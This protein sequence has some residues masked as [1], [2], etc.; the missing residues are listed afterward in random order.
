MKADH[1]DQAL[2]QKFA[3][4]GE[5]LVF[6]HD[7]ESEFTDYVQRG[8]AGELET[9]NVLEIAKVGGFAAKLRLE[10]DD[11]DG[12]YLIY[13]TGELPR[14]EEDWLLDIRLYSAAFH[15]DIASLWLNELSL[16]T[17]LYLR[18]H[19]KSRA[20]FMGAKDRRRKLAQLVS[21]DDDEESIDRKMIAVLVGS[22]DARPEA[23]IQALCHGHVQNGKF[24]L[25]QIPDSMVVLEKMSLIDR[26]W[27]SMEQEYGYQSDTPSI[28]GLLRCLFVSELQHQIDGPPIDSLVQFT[29]P[30]AGSRNAIVCLTHWRD[31]T[32]R[33][34]SYM[35]AA[36]A[37]DREL[38]ITEKLKDLELAALENVFSFFGVEKLIASMLK[39]RVLEEAAAV[40]VDEV[41]SVVSMRKA[42]HWLSGQGR[43]GAQQRAL[44]DAYDA[45]VA[46][47]ELFSL[48]ARHRD[49]LK[50]DTPVAI[51]QAYREEL[52]RIDQLYR[53][54]CQKSRAASGRGWDLLK[55]LGIRVE[56]LYQNG[57][58]E[59]LGRH[60]S[61]LLDE[62]FLAEWSCDDLPAQ[63]QFFDRYIAT[64]L[65]ESGRK[66]AFVIVSDALRYE[67]AHELVRMINGRY[68][69]N[70]KLEGTLGV[71]PSYT[72]LGMA[73]L[74]PHESIE[75]NAK[76][77]ILLDGAVLRTIDARDK[78]LRSVDGMACRA[79]DL[80]SMKVDESREF[81]QDRRI[82]YAYHDVIDARGDHAATEGGAFQA[83]EDCLNELVELAEFFVNRFN[84]TK[85]WIT[86]DHGFLYQQS[87]PT[88]TDKSKLTHKPEQ[89]VLSKKRYVIG[90]NLGDV[91]E[92]HHGRIEDTVGAGGG[93]EFWIPRGANRFHFAG[94]ARYVHGGAMP[95]EVLVP[96]VTVSQV[97]GQGQESSRAEK[98]S[99]AILG[100]NHKITTPRYR[101]EVMQTEPVGERRLPITLRAAVYDGA[102][103]VSTVVSVACDSASGNI[104]ERKKT[105][106]IELRSGIYDK[107][108]PYRFVLRDADSDAEVESMPVIIDRSFD[109][110]F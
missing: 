31:S 41:A 20:V 45:I 51:F 103:A 30:V 92:A 80:L 67:A 102:E 110:D 94:G 19:M 108:R 1:I 17:C 53:H 8:L 65:A 10:R 63:R 52:F 78:H 44:A 89:A 84:A 21:T 12:K 71:L 75:Y 107:R 14:P 38:G 27:A 55:S 93:M 64:H 33:A 76:G 32:A 79:E 46:A 62:G 29:L 68:R 56:E 57:F 97:R 28:A 96:V 85:V 16:D 74:L 35:S 50:F 104:D 24:E 58:L 98:V 109:D 100:N 42:G 99:I 36:K 18:D 60:W 25:G 91:A 72:A 95:Q 4:D 15:A 54:F 11:P 22:R 47:T 61:T 87:P 66:R 23:L 39:Q 9:V 83:V 37:V 26:F 106:L 101:F 77:D 13:S 82:V 34:A 73:S 2:M 5:R 70:A 69:V 43:G 48:Q 6:W 7:A 88:I 59:P 86:A 81:I 49:H 3:K 90:P 40:D 105:V